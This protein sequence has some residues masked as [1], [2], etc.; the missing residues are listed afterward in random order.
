MSETIEKFAFQGNQVRVVMQNDE[1]WFVAKDVC[2]ILGTRTD[3]VKGIVGEKRVR[4]IN[5]NLI[6]VDNRGGRDML[7]INES[8][9]YRLAIRS[10]KPSAEKFQD[11]ITDEVLPSIRKHGAYMTPQVAQSV[12]DNPDNALILA[13]ALLAEN[14]LRIQAESERDQARVELETTQVEL[15]AAETERDIAIRE[16]AWINEG[17]A[18]TALQRNSVYSR[19]IHKLESERRELEDR[20]DEVNAKLMH[21]KIYADKYWHWRNSVGRKPKDWED[22]Y[23]DMLF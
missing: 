5:P 9:V 6:G 1:P 12:L 16:R 21:S 20:L 11:W 18:S 15:D 2:D 10:D 14:H 23:T 22:P 4:S 3:T 7:I 13:K 8:G 19:R 17:R